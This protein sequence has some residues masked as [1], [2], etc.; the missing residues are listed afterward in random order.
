[1]QIPYIVEERPDTGFNNATL[2]IRL[3]LASEIVLFGAL[4]SSYILL[5]SGTAHWPRGEGPLNVPL[6]ALNIFILVFS[7]VAVVF[8]WVG[9]KQGNSGQFK[10]WISV[11]LLYGIHSPSFSIDQHVPDHLFYDDRPACLAYHR[12]TAVNG[13]LWGQGSR[14]F[15]EGSAVSGGRRYLLAFC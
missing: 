13:Y 2:G 4:F 1:M 3:F 15:K 14:M 12:W 7:S 11:S 6:A 9:A 5:R 8:A 10:K